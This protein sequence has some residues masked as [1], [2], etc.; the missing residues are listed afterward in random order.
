MEIYYYLIKRGVYI[1][2]Q[3]KK[4]P[5]SKVLTDITNKE[6][7]YKWIDKEISLAL[8]EVKL[9]IIITL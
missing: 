5:F 2:K 9:M 3:D 4:Y 7:P 8:V 6:E 1:A